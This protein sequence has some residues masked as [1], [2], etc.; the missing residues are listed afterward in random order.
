MIDLYDRKEKK[1]IVIQNGRLIIYYG[2][3]ADKMFRRLAR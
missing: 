2:N 1:L 3:K